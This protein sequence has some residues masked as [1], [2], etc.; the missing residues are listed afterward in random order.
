V[1]VAHIAAWADGLLGRGLAL[2]PVS[3]LVRPPSDVAV[4]AK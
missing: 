4:S 2:A 3:A 1:T